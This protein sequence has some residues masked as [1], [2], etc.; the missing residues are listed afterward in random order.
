MK[1]RWASAGDIL[2]LLRRN[3]A[4][5]GLL[6]SADEVAENEPEELEALEDVEGEESESAEVEEVE[7]ENLSK[8]QLALEMGVAE[9]IKM[10]LTG[11]KERN[12]FV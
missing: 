1:S 8:Y 9:K 5:T 12:N 7:E 10:A 4:A 2:E 6:A 11:D 3:P